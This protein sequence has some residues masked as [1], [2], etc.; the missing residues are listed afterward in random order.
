MNVDRL[1]QF[2]QIGANIGVLL[3]IAFLAFELGQNRDMI[4]AQTRHDL[5]SG[6]TDL[7][8][9]EASDDALLDLIVRSDQSLEIS[10]VERLKVD[11]FRNARFR[12]W[13]DMHYQYRTGLYDEIEFSTQ[14]EAI[15]STLA[16]ARS[17]VEYWCR[18]RNR[19]SP[20]FAEE[21]DSL[22]TT[23]SC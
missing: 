16:V 14:I 11:L 4:R 21:I 15:R 7:L 17:M 13:E 18:T 2:L 6:I 8:I 20:E 9:A 19:Y 3:S 22:L 10:A 5:A 12:Y 1:N 23:Y